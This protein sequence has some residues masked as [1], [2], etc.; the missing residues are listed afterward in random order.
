MAD[1]MSWNQYYL[2][3]ALE[4]A[5]R[6]SCRKRQIGALIV[7]DNRIVST[8]YNGTPRGVPNCIDG[9]CRRCADDEIGG[10]KDLDICWCSHAE[11]NAIV[12]SAYHGIAINR[13]T[14]Y[15]TCSPCITCAKLIINAGITDVMYWAD[16]PQQSAELL[17][18]GG[19]RFERLSTT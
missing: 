16:Y 4:V 10:G 2:N 12:Q 1:R 18:A 13:G 14:L 17:I 5:R 11:E 19:V 8:G 3:I 7:I 6:S 9:G 15:T